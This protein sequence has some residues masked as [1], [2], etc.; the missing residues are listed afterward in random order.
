MAAI[1]N[2]TR[3]RELIFLASFAASFFIWFNFWRFSSPALRVVEPTRTE[4]LFHGHI[5]ADIEPDKYADDE[6][7]ANSTLGVRFYMSEI[8]SRF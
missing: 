8:T 7:E 4:P 6:P 5:F 2:P 1:M 3:R